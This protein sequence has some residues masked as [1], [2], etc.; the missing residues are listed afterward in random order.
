[1]AAKEPIFMIRPLDAMRSGMKDCVIATMAKKFASKQAR[2]SLRGTS[3]AG[4]V[5]FRPL[6]ER[7]TY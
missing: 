7:R 3:S 6:V 1:M 5:Q 2:A 4:M